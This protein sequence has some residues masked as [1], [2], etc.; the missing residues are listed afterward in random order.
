[1]SSAGSGVD[2]WVRGRSSTSLL[3]IQT[4]FLGFGGSRSFFHRFF[5]SI[6]VA[7]LT[8]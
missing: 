3:K 6:H 7:V 2:V 4:E 5:Q 8:I 1:M